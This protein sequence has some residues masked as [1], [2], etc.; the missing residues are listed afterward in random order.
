MK[1]VLESLTLISISVVG[2]ANGF[3]PS[4]GYHAMK[5]AMSATKQEDIYEQEEM[6]AWNARNAVDPGMEAAMGERCVII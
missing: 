4:C 5:V 1:L 3:V 2:C 6:M